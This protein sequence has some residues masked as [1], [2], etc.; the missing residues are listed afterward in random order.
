MFAAELK[1]CVSLFAAKCAGRAPL[2][3]AKFTLEMALA[4]ARHARLI[5]HDKMGERRGQLE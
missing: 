1:A 2:V 4:A 3:A 5:C